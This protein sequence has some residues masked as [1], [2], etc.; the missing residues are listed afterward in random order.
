MKKNKHI[1]QKVFLD[2]ETSSMKVANSLKNN[3]VVFIK[4]ELLS[5]IESLFNE[6]E[7]HENH[8]IQI[9]KINLN[10]DDFDSKK[11][12]LSHPDLKIKLKQQ[13]EKQLNSILQQN[14]IKNN[15]SIIETGATKNM[16]ISPEDK[17]NNTLIYFLKYG[18]MPW[19]A[20][21]E[22]DAIF[23]DNSFNMIIQTDVFRA[24]LEQIISQIDV[25]KRII[26][27]FNNHQIASLI[28]S[29]NSKLKISDLT[30]ENLII[31]FLNNQNYETKKEF[32]GII[33]NYLKGN[34]IIKIVL[35]FKKH[36]KNSKETSFS[37]E[38]YL[39]DLNSFLVLNQNEKTLKSILN[40]DR[41]NNANLDEKYLFEKEKET[42]SNSIKKEKNTNLKTEISSKKAEES[43]QKLEA[44]NTAYIENAGL[45]LLHPFLKEL[46][47]K[48]ALLS[49]NNTIINK[50][51][52]VHVLHYVATKK[53][54]DF[55]HNMLFEKFL[56]GIPI[57]QS[58]QRE[59]ILENSYKNNV[60]ELLI[61]V[62]DYW[63][64]LKNSSTDILRTEFL[65]REGK[66][67]LTNVNP[68][69][70]V[71]RKTQDILLDRIP[72]NISIAKIPWIEKLIYTEW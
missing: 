8:I 11:D 12:I 35:F 38:K 42:D 7:I 71:E 60:E 54:Q 31:S 9:E 26:N 72:W 29:L 6:L 50:E 32:W 23:H 47:K 1:I 48:C 22:S 10:L 61:S 5:M 4:N 46:F 64:A 34:N 52:A 21:K 15:H 56:C 17:K 67:D 66:L 36:F 58:I 18:Q 24:N 65:Q 53:E 2:V 51:L 16:L 13:L 39:A 19:W 45:I 28:A 68:K 49:D 20:S 30:S 14:L 70:S 27:Q 63:S 44:K 57:Q 33:F 62:V 69:L 40:L 3:A 55:E 37:L 59:I 41:K 25:Q 43:I